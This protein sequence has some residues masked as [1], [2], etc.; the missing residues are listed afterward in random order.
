MAEDENVAD[1]EC[2]GNEGGH[3]DNPE[4]LLLRV[5]VFY[6]RVFVE[7]VVLKHELNSVF[8]QHLFQAEKNRDLYLLGQNPLS[9]CQGLP[10][11]EMMEHL[12]KNSV[13]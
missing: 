13:C 11:K 1:G 9:K 5:I 12:N 3:D 10:V 6:A 4:L 8:Q 2:E 7:E